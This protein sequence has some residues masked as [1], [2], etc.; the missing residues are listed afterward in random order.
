[1]ELLYT[2]GSDITGTGHFPGERRERIFHGPDSRAGVAELADAADSKSAV[3][4][5]T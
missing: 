5:G 3:P 2:G 4:D 1:M